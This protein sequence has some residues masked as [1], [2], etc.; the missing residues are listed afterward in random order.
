MRARM[1]LAILL[2]ACGAAP[3]GPGDAGSDAARVQLPRAPASALPAAT[4]SGPRVAIP[5]GTVLA[6][7]RPG[8]P[9]RRPS[10]EADL[11][12]IDVPGFEIDRRADTSAGRADPE[13]VSARAA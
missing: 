3:A 12:A 5:R 7:S 1:L 10:L 8:T 11:A 4:V 9:W 13:R 2:A 6:G